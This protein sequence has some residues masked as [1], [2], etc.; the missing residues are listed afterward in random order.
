MRLMGVV[1]RAAK[2]EEAD[3]AR[4]EAMAK[5]EKERQEREAAF[6][7]SEKKRRREEYYRYVHAD[8]LQ[9]VLEL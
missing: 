3:K 1:F 7:E 6:K 5:R 4:A 2:R 9:W 8:V